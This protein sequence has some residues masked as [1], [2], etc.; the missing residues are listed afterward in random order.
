MLWVESVHVYPVKGLRGAAVDAA[1]VEPWGL[2]GDRRWML[3]NADGRFQTQRELPRLTQARALVAADGR[4]TVRTTEL[5]ELTVVP[6]PAD[7]PPIEVRIWHDLVPAVLAD[8]EAHE[9]FSKLLDAD[10]R[11]VYFADPRQRQVDQVFGQPA[12]RVSLADG[13]PLLLTTT[14]SLARLNEWLLTEGRVD[15]ALP[16]NRFRPSVVVTDDGTSDGQPWAEDD[17]RRIR[18]GSVPFRV[19]KPCGRCV[20]TTIDQDTGIRGGEPLRILGERRK[21][22]GKLVFGQNLVPDAG[23]TIAVGDPVAVTERA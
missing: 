10:V 8:A 16:M 12:D 23:G 18:I 3:V 21:F 17:W 4:L 22:D 1:P 13:Y 15:E 19:A 11:L 5:P 7:A 9:W 2:A 6:P 20:V 14:A